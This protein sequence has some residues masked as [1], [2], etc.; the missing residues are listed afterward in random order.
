MSCSNYIS[1]AKGESL[2]TQ[3]RSYSGKLAVLQRVLP[4]YRV[5]FFKLLEQS[6]T[7]GMMLY[8]GA[9]RP[10]E[11]INPLSRYPFPV[12]KPARNIHLFAGSLYLCHQTGLIRWLEEWDPDALIVEANPRYTATPTAVGWMH[13]RGRKV[14]GWGL[15]SPPLRGVWAPFRRKR[16]LAFLC[17]FDAM[18]AYSRRGAQEYAQLGFPQDR[19]TVAYNAVRP[20]PV[21]PLPERAAKLADHPTV[22]FV[23]RLQVRKR[24]D[25]L[26]R[27]CAAMDSRPK[28]VIAGDGPERQNLAALAKVVYPSSEFVGARRNDEL[29]PLFMD[30]D[31]FVLPGTGGLAV[32]EA[33]SYGL[34]VIVAKGDGTQDDL[35]RE[36]N[37]WQV[38][39]DD[40]SA[41]ILAMQEALSD[42]SW[43]RRM[44]AESYRIARQEINIEKMVEGFVEA[45]NAD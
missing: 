37:G 27:A 18:I 14:I 6:C 12:Y 33:M 19:I 31:L 35:V 21:Y 34:P 28:V 36:A 9:A 42:A 44:G 8:A 26:L 38:P 40:L 16:K 39:A 5:P 4:D 41:L 45:L 43:L 2:N 24:V 32:Q 3:N 10:S 23:G 29:K 17:H 7:G 15:G 1:T 13:Q 22:L 20:A 11:G 30:A 25:L